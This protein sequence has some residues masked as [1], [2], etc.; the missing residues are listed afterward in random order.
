MYKLFLQAYKRAGYHAFFQAVF[1]GSEYHCIN[2]FL[3]L[4]VM[5][6]TNFNWIP[7]N[8]A[9]ATSKTHFSQNLKYTNPK[10][11]RIVYSYLSI[12]IIAIIHSKNL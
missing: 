7:I 2:N 12:V 1:R 11:N 6:K 10:R 9:H 5:Y 8:K 3:S 4:L